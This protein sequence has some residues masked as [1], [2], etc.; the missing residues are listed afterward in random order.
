MQNITNSSAGYAVNKTPAN[1]ARS[2]PFS[3]EVAQFKEK[4]WYRKN[5]PNQIINSL[6]AGESA[7]FLSVAKSV[8]LA[9]GESVYRHGD[10]IKYIYFP[11]T[12]ILSQFQVLEDGRTCEIAMIGREGCAGLSSIFDS[13]TANCWTE[14]SVA[15]S[16]LRI[17]SEI[18]KREFESGGA[19][20]AKMAEYTN[21][22]IEQLSQRIVCNYF[23]QVKERFCSWL[24]MLQDR[25]EENKF[26]FTQEGIARLLGVHRPSLS[27]VAKELQQSKLISY[28]RGQITILDREKLE[29]SACSCCL[30]SKKHFSVARRLDY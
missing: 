25:R 21:Y 24:L 6:P 11:V 12:A 29:T 5:L 16:M 20:R 1:R 9:A 14:V 18:F 27:C 8:D 22:Y 4:W 26:S 2:R 7:Y 23:H 19:L 3:N 15:G 28:S 30:T 17:D 10:N 13:S